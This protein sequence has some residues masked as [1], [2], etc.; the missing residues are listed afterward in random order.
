MSV[1]DH[2][3]HRLPKYGDGIGLHRV[4]FLMDACHLDPDDIARRAVAVTGS[5]GKGSTARIA[6]ELLHVMGGRV[7][8]FTSPHLYR[9]NERFRIDGEPVDDARLL[10]AMD[11]V[12]RAVEDYQSH[13]P[14]KI[15]AFEAQF[16]AALLVLEDCR[17]LVL[18][19][20][21]GGRYD[22]VRLARAPVSALVSLDLEHTELLGKTLPEIAFDKLDATAK[23][24]VAI[25]GESCPPFAE[26]IRAYADL[27]G[28]QI[29]FL[30]PKHWRDR[31]ITDGMQ[32]FDIVD[33]GLAFEGLRSQL[34]G[35]H[36][37]NNHA[38][39]MAL[40]RERLKQSGEWPRAGIDERWREAIARVSWPGRLETIS[41]DP[42]VVIDVGHTPEG[43]KAA[44]AGFRALTNGREAVLVTGSSKNKN[45]REM[46]EIFALAFDRIIC[47][48][49]YHNGLPATDVEAIARTIHPDARTALCRT[50]EDAV[51]E[52]RNA[53]A[54]ADS[55]I[56]V[57]GGLFLATEFAEAWRD[58]DPAKLRFF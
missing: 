13:H 54:R 1:L 38:V 52:A 23:G 44:L 7:G 14:D 22:P 48:A 3:L 17:W 34:V 4:R 49:A 56:Y 42:L 10:A 11:R 31:G 30:Q 46:L 12:A 50:I 26:Q 40:V 57:A 43:I 28:I 53:A 27:T 20:G 35:R 37:I 16:V 41:R 47:T 36:Q 19:A 32:H 55:A 39:A 8:L 29:E 24:G 9:Y 15:G 6:A 18:E 58:G 5:N 33:A 2:P 21:I 25:L 45:V 51:I